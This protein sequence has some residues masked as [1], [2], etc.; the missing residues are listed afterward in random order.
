[1]LERPDGRSDVSAEHAANDASDDGTEHD[2]DCHT[3]ADADHPHCDTDADVTAVRCSPRVPLEGG[4]ELFPGRY[5][6]QFKPSLTMTID[7]QVNLDCA[8][9]YRCRGDVNVN[10]PD[11]LDVE[12]GHDH[13]IEMHVMG[14]D[15]VVAPGA[16][17]PLERPPDDLASW[18]AAMPGVT[19]D[20][21]KPITIGGIPASQLDLQT[22]D[23]DVTFGPVSGVP[24]FPTLG[25]GAH[26]VHRVDVLRIGPRVVVV[27]LGPV[28]AEDSTKDRLAAAI[29]MLQPIVDSISWQ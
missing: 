15:K 9:G 22:G 7:R 18:I 20:A 14:F 24:E 25:L 3:D 6:T 12:F 13:P 21:S 2:V 26:Q 17:R 8:Q 19:I 29:A 5:I 4:G 10:L 11:W 16:S 1:M 23:H 28:R 27:G